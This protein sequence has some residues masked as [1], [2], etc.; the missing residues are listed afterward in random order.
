MEIPEHGEA[1]PDLSPVILSPRPRPASV[2]SEIFEVYSPLTG[3]FVLSH[4]R[5]AHGPKITVVDCEIEAARSVNH[6]GII[7]R[8]TP[9]KIRIPRWP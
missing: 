8:Q 9:R 7:M 3:V 6:T 5:T 4:R 2:I 1:G